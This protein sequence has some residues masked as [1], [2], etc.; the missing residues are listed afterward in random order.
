MSFQ[1]M[2]VPRAFI[3]ERS[4]MV[5]IETLGKNNSASPI[6]QIGAIKFDPDFREISSFDEKLSIPADRVADEETRQWWRE[7]DEPL[8]QSLLAAGRPVEQVLPEFNRWLGWSPILWAWPSVFDLPFIESYA[9]R[10]Y[11]P[12]LGT[13][14]RSRWVDSRSW[15]AGLRRD[16][17]GQ[18]ELDQMCKAKPPF[19]GSTHDALFDSRWQVWVLAEVARVVCERESKPV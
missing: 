12:M 17:I 6:I 19:E 8:L 2:R 15:I 18:E 14:W 13:I 11:K 1:T 9:R 7:T 3:P 4:V 16:W 5:D 10:Y